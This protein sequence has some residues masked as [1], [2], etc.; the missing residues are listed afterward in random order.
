MLENS[1]SS[2]E[3][4]IVVTAMSKEFSVSSH[5]YCCVNSHPFTIGECGGAMQQ[6]RC[7]ECD[8]PIGGQNH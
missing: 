8:A 7:P 1:I 2:A 3:M 4:R 6:A 5:W